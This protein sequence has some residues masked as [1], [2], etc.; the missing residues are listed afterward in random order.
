MKHFARILGCLTL[1]LCAACGS[2]PG[3]V[4]DD[5]TPAE[6]TGTPPPKEAPPAVV[7]FLQPMRD[8]IAEKKLDLSAGTSRLRLPKPPMLEFPPGKTIFWILETS[9]GTIKLR[10]MPDVAPMHVSSTIYL[11]LLGFYDGLSF[12][13]IIPNFM[14]QGGCPMGTG[15]GSPGYAY[16]GEFDQSVRHDRPGLLSMANAG[17]GTDG[18]QFFITFVPTPHLDGKHTIFGEVVEGM[19]TVKELEKRG[20]Q[21]GATTER[22]TL[23]KATILVE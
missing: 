14:A 4:P 11:T 12:H 22:V 9:C 18:S 20:T 23:K 21:S 6:E 7:D 16:N 10:L 13:R 1:A 5:S 2:E 15:T 8:F 19:D 3:R 17:P